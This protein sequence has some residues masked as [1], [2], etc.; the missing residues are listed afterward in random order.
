[1]ACHRRCAHRS[2]S[3][4]GDEEESRDE[5]DGVAALRAVLEEKRVLPWAYLVRK[6]RR[7][8]ARRRYWGLLGQRLQEY[9]ASLRDRLRLAWPKAELAPE[10]SGLAWPTRV[11]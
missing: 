4:G 1:M 8:R 11:M 6:L 10:M 2:C 7:V 3:S 5:E 9:A